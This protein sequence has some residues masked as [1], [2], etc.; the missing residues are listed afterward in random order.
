MT[1]FRILLIF[2]VQLVFARSEKNNI[3]PNEL[4][5]LLEASKG[6]V[7]N[8]EIEGYK[9]FSKKIEDQDLSAVMV[10]YETSIPLSSIQ[11]VLM[12]VENYES[13]LSSSSKMVTK[14]LKKDDT[15]VVGYQFIPINLP[16]MNDRHYCFKLIKNEINVENSKT[17]VK[18]FL[19]DEDQ[20]LLDIQSSNKTNPIYLKY[21]AGLWLVDS[22]D[23]SKIK[24]SYR[25]FM[26][27]G[28][29]IP[30]FLTEK[31]NEI[32]IINLFKDVIAE[33]ERRTS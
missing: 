18:W 5:R 3:E 9:L 22:I 28:G 1:F 27:P 14:Q 11:E 7:M 30:N 26:D 31:I 6:W 21:G 33:A 4:Y 12:D 15:A 24:I 17:L 2:V 23:K 8:D 32:S 10:T 16:F 25:L 29:S 19:L 13:F 20:E